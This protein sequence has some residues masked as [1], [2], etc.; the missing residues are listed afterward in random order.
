V[1]Q[2]AIDERIPANDFLQWSVLRW[3]VETGQR[4]VDFVGA[5]PS[6]DDPK[7][8]AIDAFKARWGTRLQASL[9]LSLP[10]DA[11][12]PRLAS[13]AGRLRL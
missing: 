5:S 1:A 2:W 3:A 4:L 6:S 12:R 8:H 11:F 7:V 10:G 9:T 13:L